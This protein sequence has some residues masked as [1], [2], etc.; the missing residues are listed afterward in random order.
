M[1]GSG[2]ARTPLGLLRRANFCQTLTYGSNTSA[3]QQSYGNVAGYLFQTA[4]EQGQLGTSIRQGQQLY[5][6]KVN[7][8]SLPSAR[9]ERYSM[10]DQRDDGFTLQSRS[11]K[12]VLRKR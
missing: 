6:E 3:T 9:V 1:S 5:I 10:S 12:L 7:G 11:G 4:I 2:T 8:E